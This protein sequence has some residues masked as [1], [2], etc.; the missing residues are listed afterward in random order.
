MRAV[1]K[2]DGDETGD[3]SCVSEW[4][5]EGGDEGPGPHLHEVNVEV[6]YVV[7]GVMT[8]LAGHEWFEASRGSFLPVPAG[9]SHDF[10]SRS[11]APARV[12]NVF[13]PGGFEPG[14]DHRLVHRAVRHQRL[15]QH[16][17]LG[18]VR[19]AGSD[20][21]YARRPARIASARS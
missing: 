2:A 10:A 11:D 8:F 20:A 4:W 21:A 14:D 1:F 7:E 13:M 17:G 16:R 18:R 6:F 12:L 3:A 9:V 5:L 19:G 15:T